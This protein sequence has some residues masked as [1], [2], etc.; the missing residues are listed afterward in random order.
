MWP[1]CELLWQSADSAGEYA[2]ARDALNGCAP[3]L[4][5][6]QQQMDRLGAAL[7]LPELTWQPIPVVD[8]AD[9]VHPLPMAQGNYSPDDC[10]YWLTV[11][12]LRADASDGSHFWA[13]LDRFCGTVR[14]LS[15]RP[16]SE[17]QEQRPADAP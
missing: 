13:E 6:L 2:L 17:P 3:T 12:G 9:S 10:N 15:R 7:G 16:A 1:Y 4:E 14:T 8:D 11:I 5:E